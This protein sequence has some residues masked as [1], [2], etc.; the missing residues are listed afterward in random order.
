MRRVCE[1]VFTQVAR[2]VIEEDS[3]HLRGTLAHFDAGPD[4]QEQVDA[5]QEFV[6]NVEQAFNQN[7]QSSR[8]NLTDET[9]EARNSPQDS[10]D[11]N[12]IVSIFD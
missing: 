2:V 1:C 4:L 11:H 6:P 7:G 8:F 5:H 12:H 3:H 9:S 10:C